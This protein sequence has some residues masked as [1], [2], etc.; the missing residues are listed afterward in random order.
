[1]KTIFHIALA[2][3]LTQSPLYAIQD[4]EIKDMAQLLIKGSELSKDDQKRL[5]LISLE[6]Y[7]E[8]KQQ[9]L[10]VKLGGSD[11]ESQSAARAMQLLKNRTQ[12]NINAAFF[13]A[14]VIWYL[15]IREDKYT[16]IP[17]ISKIKKD[18]PA[19]RSGLLVGDVI[20]ACAGRPIIDE[21]STNNFIRLMRLWPEH[22]PMKLAIRRSHHANITNPS[23][24]NIKKNLR[25]S[26]ELEKRLPSD[27]HH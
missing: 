17:M 9:L 4:T 13:G 21:A 19:S 8:L 6:H 3:L 20:D 26:L 10:I 24:K 12:K 27:H 16:S 15:I 5:A 18:S 22:T 25:L 14:E 7:Q 2:A 1:M 23:E 11:R